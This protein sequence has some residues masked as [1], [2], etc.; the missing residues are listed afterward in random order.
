MT[1]VLYNMK[2]SVWTLFRSLD[3]IPDISVEGIHQVLD[4]GLARCLLDRLTGGSDVRSA[5]SAPF[6]V[7]RTDCRYLRQDHAVALAQRRVRLKRR[8]LADERVQPRAEDLSLV[9]RLRQVLLVD[10]SSPGGIDQDRRW[11]HR[12]ELRVGDQILG[13]GGEGDVDR[14]DVTRSQE[15]IERVDLPDLVGGDLGV[16]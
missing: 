4:H 3:S 10:D 5:I 8:R 16:P 1:T 6:S 9:Q 14:D 15:L 2:R 11:L 13:A 12:F 7:A